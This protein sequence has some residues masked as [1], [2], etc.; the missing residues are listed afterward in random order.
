MTE[1]FSKPRV[2][3][4]HSKKDIE[5]VK[6]LSDDLKKCQI[7]PWLDDEEIRHGQPWLSA[8][9]E[10]GLPTCDCVLI[11]LTEDSI[12]SSMVKKE[13]D[14]GVIGK[15]SDNSIGFLPYV[16]DKCMRPLLRSDLQALQTPV[17]DLSNY[18]EL[19]PLVVSEIWRSYMERKIFSAVSAE[20][21]RRLEAEL[22]LQAAKSNITNGPFNASETSDFEYVYNK[23][24]RD[25]TFTVIIKTESPLMLNKKPEQISKNYK[26]TILSILHSLVKETKKQYNSHIVKRIL[27]ESLYP[28]CL[29]REDSDRHGISDTPDLADDFFTYGMMNRV[30]LAPQQSLGVIQDSNKLVFSD[31]FYR[32]IYWLEYNDKDIPAFQATELLST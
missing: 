15:L 32:F 23:L 7:E 6:N 27:L 3:L 26:F 10:D 14:A 25:A 2:F 11:Y 20:K 18:S 17:W 30:Q 21:V 29:S 28:N 8:I 4:S 19:L 31:K 1:R 12:R 13:I 5:F 24:N 22:E 9:F 16:N